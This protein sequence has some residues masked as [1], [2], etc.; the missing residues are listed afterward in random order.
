MLGE[1]NPTGRLVLKYHAQ[2]AADLA[3]GFWHDGRPPIV[4][5]AVFTPKAE[6][7]LAVKVSKRS[8]DE[9]LKRILGSLNVCSKEWVIRQYD[10]EV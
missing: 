5:E 4:R 6:V 10:H 9:T 1:F 7:P 8:H 3:M 2:Q